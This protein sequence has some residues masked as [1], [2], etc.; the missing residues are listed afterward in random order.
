MLCKS[1]WTVGHIY[2]MFLCLHRH[3]LSTG[4]RVRWGRGV[5]TNSDRAE[6]ASPETEGRAREEDDGRWFWWWGRRQWGRRRR[7]RQQEQQQSVGRLG[8]FVGN[9]W[10]PLLQ[11]VRC[12]PYVSTVPLNPLPISFSSTPI[13]FRWSALQLRSPFQRKMRTRKILSQQSFTKTKKLHIWKTQKRLCRAST[14]GKVKWPNPHV[15]APFLRFLV[16]LK[17]VSYA[18]TFCTPAGEE[19]EFEYEDKSHGTWL[20]RIKWVVWNLWFMAVKV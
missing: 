15:S 2:H 20:C 9:G 18:V 16:F 19:L 3:S 5:W 13:C 10:A 1:V 12:H 14:T 4:A 7:R 6:R 8:L 11:P 17:L